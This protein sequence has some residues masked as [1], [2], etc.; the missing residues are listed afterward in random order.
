MAKAEKF[1][2]IAVTLVIIA[3]GFLLAVHGQTKI[4]PGMNLFSPAQDVELGRQAA[5]ETEQHLPILNDPDSTAYINRLGKTLVKN[6]NMP[7]LPWQFKLVNASEVNAF[8]LPGGFI[9]VHRGLIEAADTEGQLVGVLCHEISHVTL[10]HG[11][12]QV[13]KAMLAQAP[14]SF[15]GGVSGGKGLFAQLAQLGI[16][17]GTNLTFMKFSRTAETQADLAGVQ[18]MVRSGYNPE[19]MVRM[20][21]TLEHLSKGTP[22]KFEMW[23]ASHPTPE[24]R[25]G[26]LNQEIGQ[27]QV[28]PH[29]IKNSMQFNAI[30]RRLHGMPPAPKTPAPTPTKS[31]PESQQRPEP[32]SQRLAAYRHPQNLYSVSYPA[33]WKALESGSGALFAPEHGV[34]QTGDQQRIVYGVLIN[35]FEPHSRH[36]DP[37]KLTLSESTDELVDHLIHGN[38]YLAQINER[39][40]GRLAGAEAITVTLAGTPKHGRAEIVELIARKVG[41]EIFYITLIAPEAEFRTYQ[42]AFRAMSRTLRIFE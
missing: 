18:L 38:P 39:Q 2:S 17:V 27:L 36:A 33:N 32:P 28:A 30:R 41:A 6:T 31:H 21:E 29:S 4:K 16:G 22:S 11:T 40:R 10:R 15:L 35:L 34:V 23:F 37:G 25:I 3:V 5:Q 19:E 26:R 12:N 14:L 8:A 42:P 20:F 13:S 1:K 7:D 24:N 9:Y